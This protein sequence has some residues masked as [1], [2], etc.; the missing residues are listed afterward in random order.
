ME[1]SKLTMDITK[2]QRDLREEIPNLN[3]GGC[4]LFAYLLG[5]KLKREGIDF[6]VKILGG[7]EDCFEYKVAVLNEVKNN[8]NNLYRNKASFAHCY[9]QIGDYEFDGHYSNNEL[10]GVF[11]SLDDI[12]EYSLQDLYLAIKVG[13]WNW[14]FCLEKDL[15]KLE[16]IIENFKIA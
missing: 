5:K 1:K 11:S 6:K 16:E 13:S 4:G 10:R 3:W 15:P 8:R 7:L 14:R 2:L 9:L 12:G